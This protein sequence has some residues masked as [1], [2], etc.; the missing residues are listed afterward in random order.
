MFKKLFLNEIGGLS[1]R[2][3]GAW[4]AGVCG[5]LLAST[6]QGVELPHT[7]K[8]VCVIVGCLSIALNQVGAAA[9]KDRQT[10]TEPP[11]V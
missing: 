7:V 10:T 6:T 5:A 9:A 8:V 3:T 4:I 11:K 1:F 2:R